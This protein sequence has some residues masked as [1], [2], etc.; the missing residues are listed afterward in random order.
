[1]ADKPNEQ[2]DDRVIEE[3]LDQM[4]NSFFFFLSCF[5]FKVFKFAGKN[6]EVAIFVGVDTMIGVHHIPLETRQLLGFTHLVFVFYNATIHV[7]PSKLL[8]R[9]SYYA[10]KHS[11]CLCNM[12]FVNE[13]KSK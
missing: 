8:I 13:K 10:S 2:G 6:K 11:V 12:I 3:C 1:V 9:L 4:F 5:G 7:T